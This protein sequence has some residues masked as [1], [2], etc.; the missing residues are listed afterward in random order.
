MKKIINDLI[1][2]EK[3]SLGE[4]KKQLAKEAQDIN[5]N[6]ALNDHQEVEEIYLL[7]KMRAR[8]RKIKELNK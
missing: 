5:L 1:E 2:L 3:S 4:D 7:I 6:I 8:I